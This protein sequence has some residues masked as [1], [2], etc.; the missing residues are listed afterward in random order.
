ML[1][2]LYIAE[3]IGGFLWVIVVIASI[4]GQIAKASKRSKQKQQEGNA[5]HPPE[6][7]RNA[8]PVAPEDQLQDFLR[9]LTGQP[10]QEPRPV[11]PVP[12]P[13]VQKPRKRQTSLKRKKQSLRQK[14]KAQPRI[15][16]QTANAIVP[17]FCPDPTVHPVMP[18]QPPMTT[19]RPSSTD[20][21]L[22]RISALGAL[23]SA[24]VW[25]EILGPPVAL[26]QTST[27]Q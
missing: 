11:A 4:A 2:H 13:V 20:P 15:K 24:I 17:E 6:P 25:R 22:K 8:E 1:N 14:K 9:S 23:R 19:R 7:R 3:G 18:I 21:A 16:R 26:R 5:S 27:P 10:P 12:A